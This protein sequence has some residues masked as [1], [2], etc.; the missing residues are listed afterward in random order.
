[1]VIDWTS[2]IFAELSQKEL[3]DNHFWNVNFPHL[4]PGKTPN[5][6]YCERS[7]A[8]MDIAY[9]KIDSS[10]QYSGSYVGRS[11]PA[12]SD[13]DVCFGGDIA[14]TQVSL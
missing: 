1:M 12:N 11:R 9:S 8:P 3:K 2:K 14:I 10:Y 6:V 4:A 13:V 5:I 7:T